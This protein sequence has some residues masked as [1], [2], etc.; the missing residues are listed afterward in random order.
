MSE[1]MSPSYT[2]TPDFDDQGH[3]QN[4]QVQVPPGQVQVPPAQGQAQVQDPAPPKEP[5]ASADSSAR[6]ASATPAIA[7]AMN[8][9]LYALLQ[10]HN[11]P[12][13]V[14]SH[15]VSIDIL[16]TPLF[17]NLADTPAELDEDVLHP[18]GLLAA[19]PR[20]RA[21]LKATARAAWRDAGSKT[22][23]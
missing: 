16:T 10:R 1:T 7:S 13:A 6:V 11:V 5:S 3:V 23:R 12:S 18:V 21:L 22:L 4:D 2:P 14:A 17:A 9:G 19:A 20:A 8:P 15:L